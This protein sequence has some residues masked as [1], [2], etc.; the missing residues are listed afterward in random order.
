MTKMKNKTSSKVKYIDSGQKIYDMDVDGLPKREIKQKLYL[1]RKERF[2][3]IKA[4]LATYF[5]VYLAVVACFVIAVI[6]VYLWL[7]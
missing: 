5:P 3:V 7:K 6:L 2:A 1:N 4:A